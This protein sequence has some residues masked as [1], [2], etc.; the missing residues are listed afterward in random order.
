MPIPENLRSMVGGNSSALS[1][2]TNILL[3]AL[4]GMQATLGRIEGSMNVLINQGMKTTYALIAVIAATVGVEFFPRSPIRWA[5]AL[6]NSSKFLSILVIVFLVLR[7]VQHRKRLLTSRYA[8]CLPI[9]LIALAGIFIL[10]M[11]GLTHNFYG[12]I[13]LQLLRLT[14]WGSFLIY[15]LRIDGVRRKGRKK[16]NSKAV[17]GRR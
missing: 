10:N 7:M 13:A 5:D 8:V 2:E 4:S 6:S 11:N 14:F 17:C 15:A 16:S 1:E 3:A 9:G 12:Q